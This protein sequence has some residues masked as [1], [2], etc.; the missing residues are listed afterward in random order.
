MQNTRALRRLSVSRRKQASLRHRAGGKPPRR[1]TMPTMGRTPHR[2]RGIR[3][4][5]AQIRG[6]VA[7]PC[8]GHGVAGPQATAWLAP[9]PPRLGPP[10]AHNPHTCRSPSRTTHTCAVGRAP[11]ASPHRGGPLAHLAKAPR[12]TPEPRRMGPYTPI[13]MGGTIIY[14]WKLI[15][16]L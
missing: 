4:P 16:V 1:P 9:L 2:R 5:A 8:G 14:V 11:Q 12:H 7:F 3:H 13:P 6:D 10:G 15:S